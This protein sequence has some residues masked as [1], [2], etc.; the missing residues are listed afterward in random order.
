MR[1]RI[2]RRTRRQGELR[3]MSIPEAGA[4]FYGIGEAASYAAAARGEIPYIQVG[5][6]KR[7]PIALMEAKLASAGSPSGG[8][9]KAA[10]Q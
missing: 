10:A 6:L 3:T 7:V 8:D 4:E 2:N 5:G 1:T 9:S